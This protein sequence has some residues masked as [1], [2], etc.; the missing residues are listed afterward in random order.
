MSS[1]EALQART[2]QMMNRALPCLE[3]DPYV[4]RY[5]WFM[6]KVDMGSLD[7]VDLLVED[8]PGVLSVLGRYYF[9]R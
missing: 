3:S 1:P 8:K 4:A 6:P 9:G 2:L 5:A 7:H